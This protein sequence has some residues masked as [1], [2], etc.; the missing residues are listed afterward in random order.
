MVWCQYWKQKQQLYGFKINP[1]LSEQVFF[2]NNPEASQ[3]LLLIYWL[4][5]PFFP[6]WSRKIRRKKQPKKKK[7][8]LRYPPTPNVWWKFFSEK[9]EY[10]HLQWG[11]LES[12]HHFLTWALDGQTCLLVCPLVLPFLSRRE[13][14]SLPFLCAD[15]FYLRT[16]KA[17]VC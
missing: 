11:C 6:P 2:R 5:L 8:T 1:L 10:C 15:L 4:R 3:T 17:V 14:Q 12:Q 13:E 9:L 16:K 7:C